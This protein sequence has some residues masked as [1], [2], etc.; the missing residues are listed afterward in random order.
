MRLVRAMPSSPQL[1]TMPGWW[2][3]NLSS[4]STSRARRHTPRSNEAL[5]NGMAPAFAQGSFLFRP[6]L[7]RTVRWLGFMSYGAGIVGFIGLGMFLN[8][9]AGVPHV[10]VGL[11]ERIADY[12]GAAMLLGRAA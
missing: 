10:P 6:T 11:A 4:C 1:D 7:V 2:V 8:R 5:T 9:P 12:P 3:P